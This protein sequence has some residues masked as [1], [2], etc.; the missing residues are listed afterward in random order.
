[1]SEMPWSFLLCTSDL[2]PLDDLLGADAVRQLGDD[3]ALAAVGDRLDPGGGA[4]P[5]GPAAGLVGVADAVEA[6]DLAAGR[7]VGAGDEA[8]QVVDGRLRV[9]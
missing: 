2:D 5:E 4:H 1:M 8:H 7:Q 3:D 9:A 6:D